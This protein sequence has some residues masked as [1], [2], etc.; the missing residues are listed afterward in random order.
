MSRV[1]FA[2]GVLGH[3]GGGD[4]EAEEAGVRSGEFGPATVEKSWES[5][6]AELVETSDAIAAE[7]VSA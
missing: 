7:A 4:A 6:D 1:I 2:V 3:A 5:R